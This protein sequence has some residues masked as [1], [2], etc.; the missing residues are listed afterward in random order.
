MKEDA[1]NH[2]RP[3]QQMGFEHC[4]KQSSPELRLK[5]RG[6]ASNQTNRFEYHQRTG[7]DDGW[8]H[9]TDDTAKVKTQ[10]HNDNSKT[11]LTR[12]QSPDI[13]FDRSINPYRGCEHGCSYCFARPSHAYLG[14]SPGLDFE[15]QIMVKKDAAS[16][17]VKEL[18]NPRYDVAPIA[19]GSNTDPY[20][21]IEKKLMITRQILEVLDRYQHPVTIVTKSDLILRDKDILARMAAKNLARVIVSVTTL[22]RKLANKLEP[23][24]TTPGKRLDA[25]RELNQAGIPTGVFMAPVIPG[26]TDVELERI[27]YAAKCSGAETARYIM[28]RLPREVKALFTEWLNTHYPAKT[29]KVLNQLRNMRHGQLNNPTFFN[30]FKPEGAFAQIFSNRFRLQ[31]EKLGFNNNDKQPLRCDLFDPPQQDTQQLSLF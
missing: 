23:R 29:E 25:I 24:A 26:L 14:F 13:P 7:F 1:S 28:L 8:H 9:Q 30:R 17:L 27:L 20:Q 2:T 21:P 22:D 16:L 4:T 19:L 11:I 10:L 6:I 31:T 3:P 5:G 15:S 18:S 12:N